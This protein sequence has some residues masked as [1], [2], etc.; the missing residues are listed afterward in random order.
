MKQRSQFVTVNAL[1]SPGGVRL[2][3]VPGAWVTSEQRGLGPGPQHDNN[4]SRSP[5]DF[6]FSRCR[7]SGSSTHTVL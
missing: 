3:E 6:D 1:I 2:V 5:F 4:P 7:T